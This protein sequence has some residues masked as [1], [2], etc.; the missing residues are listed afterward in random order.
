MKYSNYKLENFLTDELFRSWVIRP[1]Q[2]SD[3]FWASY[4]EN[5]QK[6][7]TTILQA[8]EIILSLKSAKI[9]DQL[10]NEEV[11]SLLEKISENTSNSGFI[12]QSKMNWRSMDVHAGFL[13]VAAVLF[14]ISFIGIYWFFNGITVFSK[15]TIVVDSIIKETLKGEKMT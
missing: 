11:D 5:N 15:K 10:G 1:D 4:V 9:E 8:K 13:K 12:N 14:V 2:E 3:F 7:Y 6:K